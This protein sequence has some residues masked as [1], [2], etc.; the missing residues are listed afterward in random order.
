[1]ATDLPKAV[2][3]MSPEEHGRV[4]ARAMHEEKVRIEKNMASAVKR[5]ETR[6]R[7]AAEDVF[8]RNY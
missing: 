5:K 4:I 6:L 1:M 7:N 3:E 2:P 8:S